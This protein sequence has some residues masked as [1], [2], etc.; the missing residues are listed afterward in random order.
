MLD[1]KSEQLKNQ[2]PGVSSTAHYLPFGVIGVITPW[3][4]PLM[5]LA[6]KIAP[7]LAAGNTVVI[8]PSE[9][10]SASTLEFARLCAES[11][12][13]DGVI[14][15]ITGLG[16]EA[17]EP[18]VKHSLT[19][20]VTFTGSDIGGRKVAE[21][22]ASGIIPATLELGGKSPQLLFDDAVDGVS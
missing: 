9:Y 10:A 20:K 3:N 4:S 12:I 6:W 8:K 17:G 5:I 16:H 14:N 2:I 7:A 18:L 22:A 19:R 1:V 11:S 13:P 21:A 15:V